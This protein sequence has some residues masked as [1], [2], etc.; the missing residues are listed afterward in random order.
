MACCSDKIITCLIA[1]CTLCLPVG[2]QG[3]IL[4]DTIR[5]QAIDEVSIKGERTTGARAVSVQKVADTR[6]MSATGSLQISDVLKYF[7]GATVKD[8]GGI[9]GLKTVSVRGL[10]ASHTAVAYDGIIITDNQTGQID[11]GRFSASQT[12]SVRLVSGPDNDLLQSAAMAAQAATIT[13]SSVPPQLDGKRQKSRAELKYGSFNTLSALAHAAFKAGNS[14]TVSIQGEWLRT[15][16]SYPYIQNNGSSS[17]TKNRDNS[18]VNRLRA[19]IAWFGTINDKTDL[20]VRTYWFQSEQGLPANI[21]YNDNAAR[22]RLWNRDGF[23]QSTFKSTLSDRLTLKL[24][25]KYGITYTRYLNPIVNSSAGNTDNRYTE[26]EGYL[27]GVLLYRITDLLT[28]SAAI[29]G[30]LSKLDGNGA[31]QAR[32]TR[33]TLNASTALKYASERVTL[34]TRL[35]YVGTTEKT[36]L[37]QAAENYRHLS[38][39]I[40][41]NWLVWSAAGLHLRASYVNTYRLP[42]FNDLYFEQ[43]GRRDLKPERASVTSA[44]VIIEKELSNL[45]FSLYA[46]AYNSSVKDR[47]MAVPG[48]NTAVWMMKNIGHVVTH[49]IETGL[50]ISCT[51]GSI[52]PAARISYTYQRAMDKSDSGSTTWNHQIP[53]T[54]RHSA[55][56]V[57]WIETPI[58][59]VS[60]NIIFSSEYYSNGYNGPE[61][62]MP[63]YYEAGC[64]VWHDFNINST[65]A[66]FKAECINLTDSRYELVRNFPMPGRQFRITA[67]FEI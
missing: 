10:G 28:A 19:E 27:S 41:T 52:R 32:P 38:P 54:P 15:D 43:I 40:G 26:H 59:N 65:T 63:S 39:V 4:S 7:S 48:K 16:G 62:R 55:S 30:R 56:A 31:E 45:L 49:G 2:A 14:N 44:G 58:V 66:T 29:D 36:V 64:S 51:E 12:G 60:C 67:K 57:A 1:I 18:D 22:E 53:Y 33:A 21:L 13:V 42:T 34:T 47:I 25:A 6:L 3:Q 9:G 50:D 23:V 17:R 20:T 35:N 11:L 24:N 46:D 5:T 8:Y 61:Y 37:R